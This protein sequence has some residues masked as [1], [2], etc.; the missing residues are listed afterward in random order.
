MTFQSPFLGL[1]L[2]LL[3]DNIDVD[4]LLA[5]PFNP[6]FWVFLCIFTIDILMYTL[7]L[8][9]TFQSPFLGLSL[10][11]GVYGLLILLLLSSIFQS[12]FLGL[13]LH[14]LRLPAFIG[15]LKKLFQSPFLGLSLH[16][17]LIVREIRRILFAFNPLFWVFLCIPRGR[18][19]TTQK[20]HRSFQS[21][22]LGLSLHHYSRS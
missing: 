14:R 10:H 8:F 20:P 9:I 21:P 6:L 5:F 2:H 18:T 1:S 22:F 3:D 15:I 12:P 19:S 13:S 11:R 16:L 17:D 7:W 4:L